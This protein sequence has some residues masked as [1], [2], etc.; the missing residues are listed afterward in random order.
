MFDWNGGGAPVPSPAFQF[1]KRKE[2]RSV[3][4][5]KFGT[6]FQNAAK[7]TPFLHALEAVFLKFQQES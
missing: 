2:R 6:P 7:I 1:R 4:V 3:K 5:P